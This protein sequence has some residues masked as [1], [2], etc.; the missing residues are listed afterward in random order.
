MICRKSIFGGSR[1]FASTNT[2]N[3]YSTI[4]PPSP[5]S[6]RAPRSKGTTAS[7]WPRRLAVLTV[8]GGGVYL[9]DYLNAKVLTRTLRTGWVGVC[10]AVDYKMNFTPEKADDIASLHERAAKRMYHVI[11]ENGGLYIK[12]GQTIAMQST[13]LPEAYGRIFST[14]F[15]EAPQVPWSEV[16][17]LFFEEFGKSP[18]DVFASIDHVAKASASIAQVHQATLKSGERVAVKIQKPDIQKQVGW[19]LWYPYTLTQRIN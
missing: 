5:S 9:W 2:H 14:L 17:K 3:V 11:R 16:E 6:L 7:K 1:R 15:D 8:I 13:V 18:D 10:L 4:T 19:D 12:I